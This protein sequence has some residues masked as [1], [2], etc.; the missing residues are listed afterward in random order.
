MKS[1]QIQA[2]KT[3]CCYY[4]YNKTTNNSYLDRR[5]GCVS[6]SCKN[7]KPLTEEPNFKSYETTYFI[8]LR[9]ARKIDNTEHF[10]C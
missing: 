6:V 8:N 7:I 2:A 5:N 10:K 9:V 1:A 3:E 4:F